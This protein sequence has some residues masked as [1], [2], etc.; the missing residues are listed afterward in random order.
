MS[1]R[2]QAYGDVISNVRSAKWNLIF[3]L[4]R[5]STCCRRACIGQLIF[6][7]RWQIANKGALIYNVTWIKKERKRNPQGGSN[8]TS[9]IS[10]NFFKREKKK[11]PTSP[12]WHHYYII[13]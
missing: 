7:I 11:K 4:S 2:I 10:L 3:Y 13:Y 5:L 8:A 12:Q 1:A 9:F 6:L